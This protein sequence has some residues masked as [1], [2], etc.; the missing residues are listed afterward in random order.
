MKRRRVIVAGTVAMGAIFACALL[1]AP[2]NE[3]RALERTRRALRREGFRGELSDFDF[4]ASPDM[5]RRA[6][7]LTRGEFS[8]TPLANPTY[9]WSSLSRAEHPELMA[10]V[11]SD[12]ALVLRKQEQLFFPAWYPSWPGTGLERIF[13]RHCARCLRRTG[14]TWT[15]LARLPDPGQSVSTWRQVMATPC[16]FRT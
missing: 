15:K 10:G 7:A 12:A 2:D 8:R 3:Q 14:P 9:G 6:A 5:R 11:A 1:L 4:R 16:C 13:G